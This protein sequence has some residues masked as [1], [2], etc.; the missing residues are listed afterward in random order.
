MRLS[1]KIIM[2]VATLAGVVLLFVPLCH[3]QEG[4]MED[5]VYLKN[6]SIIRGMILEQVPGESLKIQT[7]DG[8]VFVFQMDEVA[9]IVKEEAFVQEAEPEPEELKKPIGS[10][11][12][13]ALAFGLSF[14]FPGAGQFYNGEAGKGAIMLGVSMAGVM[15][16]MIA[17]AEDDDFWGNSSDDTAPAMVMMPLAMIMGSWIW[18]MIDAP[19]SATR[20]NRERGWAI[21]PDKIDN[22]YLSITDL[23]PGK[24]LTPGVQLKMMF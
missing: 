12:E 5:V 19:I 21:A 9:R 4:E 2:Q 22:L 1:T 23:D 17:A 16:L 18:S 10:K 24:Q 14:F 7:R 15:V 3:S 20:I 13:P 8:S 6:G 11:K